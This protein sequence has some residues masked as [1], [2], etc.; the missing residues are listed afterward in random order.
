LVL[1]FLLNTLSPDILSDLLDVSSTAE[2]WSAIN[3]MFETASRTKAQHLRDQL[4]E[5]KKLS[6]TAGTYYTKM[7]G[8]ASELSTLGKPVE[9]D[10]MLG[11]LLHGLD[12][13]EYN[14]LITSIHGNPSTT[15]DKF[16]EQLCSYDVCLMRGE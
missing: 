8:F 12:K 13:G 4:N 15:L 7:K 5:T 3:A 6:M 2:A 10:E 11:Y 16:Y 14:A 9:E 1:W